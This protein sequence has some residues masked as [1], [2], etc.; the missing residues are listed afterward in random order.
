[1]FGALEP[2]LPDSILGVI[3]AFRSDSRP[4]KINLSVGVYQDENGRTPTLACIAEAERRLAA[5]GEEKPYLPIPGLRDFTEAIE[6]LVFGD[7]SP[8]LAEGRTATAQTPGGTGALRVAADFLHKAFPNSSVWMSKPTWPNHQGVFRAAGWHI[9]AYPYYDPNTHGID[10][11]NMR[12]GLASAQAGD[13]VLL[14]GCCHNPTGA[15]L[16]IPQWEELAS[17]F[18]E[19][20]LLPLIDFA[21]QGFGRGLEED[22]EA[23]RLLAASGREVLVTASLSKNFGMYCERVGA[24]SVVTKDT[25]QAATVMSRLKE[26]IRGNYSNPPA[27]GARAVATALGDKGLRGQWLEELTTMRDRINGMRKLFVETMRAKAPQ[28]DFSFIERQLGMFSFSGLTRGQVAALREKHAVYII[29]S[30]RINVAGMNAGAMDR[31]CSAVA[32][33]L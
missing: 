33:V 25:G 4:E 32:D 31:L 7:D 26:T 22:A 23:V 16:S 12:Q 6:R 17:I 27:H 1:M 3:E 20:Q 18:A 29:D 30:G 24:L 9:E 14:H 28:V 8:A 5:A 21:Y 19:R 11:A 10:F 13:V 2:A 15:D